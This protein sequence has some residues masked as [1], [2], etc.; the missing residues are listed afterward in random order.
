MVKMRTIPD[1]NVVLD[2][3]YASDWADWSF[4]SLERC[5]ADGVMVINAI[6]YSEISARFSGVSALD[7]LLDELAI[8]YEEIPRT[9]AFRAGRAHFAYRRAG[10]SRLRTLPDFLVGA[11]AAEN[12]Y[13]ILTRDAARYRSYFPDINIIAPDSH[14]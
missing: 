3:L 10:G 5:R 8:A 7:A 4:T 13:R 11:H 14:P 12:G 1:S 6:V 9:A 2:L